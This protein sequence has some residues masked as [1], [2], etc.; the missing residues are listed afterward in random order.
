MSTNAQVRAA[1]QSKVF[2]NINGGQNAFD[3]DYWPESRKDRSNLVYNKRVDFWL[4]TVR[5]TTEFTM[6]RGEMQHFE[7]EIARFLENVPGEKN[8]NQVIDDFVTLQGYV[9]NTLGD[10]WQSTVS[11][12][13][14]PEDSVVPERQQFEEVECWVG[15]QIYMADNIVYT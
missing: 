12:Y 14:L 6:M 5:H 2:A 13:R 4:Y 8:S 11:L 15:R 10:T 3:Y 1:W 7:V 9:R